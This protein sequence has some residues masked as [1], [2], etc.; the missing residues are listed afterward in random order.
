MKKSIMSIVLTIFFAFAFTAHATTKENN[1]GV[2]KA[3]E[4]KVSFKVFG[5][6]G[7]CKS[8]IEKAAKIDG[9]KSAEW[10]KSTK[11][12][13]I[14]YDSKKVSEEAIHNAI[15]ATGHDT[16]KVKA[17][18]EAYNTLHGCCQYERSK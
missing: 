4:K 6:C 1:P 9:V 17:T 15:T 12:I 16:E 14:K 3:S 8:R 5:N 2:V 11:E 10:N 7:M 18:D 13:S